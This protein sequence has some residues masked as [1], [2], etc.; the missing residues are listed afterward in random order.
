VAKTA[1]LANLSWAPRYR[2]GE[3]YLRAPWFAAVARAR[4]WS[5]ARQQPIEILPAPFGTIYVLVDCFVTGVD[6]T[7]TMA[8]KI[9]GDLLRRPGLVEP[10]GDLRNQV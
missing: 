8:P 6:A 10:I 4:H 9:T 7:T 3:R 5:R 1:A 2:V